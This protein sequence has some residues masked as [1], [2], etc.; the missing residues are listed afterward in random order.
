MCRSLKSIPF[1]LLLFATPAFADDELIVV[2]PTRL[3]TPL[4]QVASSITVI[5]AVDIDQKQERTL[6]DVLRDVPGLNLIQ[7]GGAG[8]TTSLFIRGAN[9]NQT[10]VLVDGIDVSDPT[11]PTGTFEFAN[12]LTGAVQ[13]VEVLRGPQSGLYGSDAIGGVVDVTTKAGSGPMKLDGSVEGGSFATFDQAA[14]VSGSADR[15]SYMFDVE[16]LRSTGAAV[17][18][19]DLLAP[20]E[21]R[22]DDAYDNLTA[23]AKLGL[24]LSDDADLG[25]IARYVRSDLRF[26]S[27]FDFG[28]GPDPAQSQTLSDQ[29]F[30]R[31]TAHLTSLDGR[32]SQ[33]LGLGYT[34]YDSTELIPNN[35]ATP[36]DGDRLKADWQADF[37]L[38]PGQLLVAGAEGQRDAI[39]GSPISASVTNAAGFLELQS[40][41]GG[42]LFDTVSVRYDRNGQFGGRATYRIAPTLVFQETSTRLK[43]SLGTGFKAPTLSELYVSFPA[44]GFSANPALRPET[45]IGYDV[46]I[47]Q[48]LARGRLSLGATW[49]H[50]AIRNLIT[51]N[52]DFTTSINVGRASTSG[53]ESFIAWRPAEGLRLRADYTYVRAWDDILDQE[54]LRRP[55]HKASVGAE[56]QAMPALALTASLLYV[57]SWID[58]NRDFS[59]PRLTAPAYVTANL[60]ANYRAGPHWSLFGRITNL[61][62]R[63]YQDPIG[64]L[65]PGRGVFGGVK[66]SF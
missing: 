27:D 36:D 58:G 48:A 47:E 30:T 38:A 18:P 34:R 17:T 65:A 29:V 24:K 66:A 46:G 12:L 35:P 3:P 14:A 41:F 6:P 51:D 31:A 59:I 61:A 16:H 25:L 54:L 1:A 2:S 62:D 50:N 43:A 52:A 42:R 28:P 20:G 63:R 10:K 13:Q 32:L 26:T 53:V 7:T 39:R 64:F 23:A 37:K 5:T 49:F 60:T 44:F 21:A 15:V 19:P 55:K 56:W 11:T 40:S 22:N 9:S 4:G 57:G 8:G 33:T 45:S